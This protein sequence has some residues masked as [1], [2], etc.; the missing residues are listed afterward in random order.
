MFDGKKSS[1]SSETKSQM[2]NVGGKAIRVVSEIERSGNRVVLGAYRDPT[3]FNE[4]GLSVSVPTPSVSIDNLRQSIENDT[5][6]N[7]SN[8]NTYVPEDTTADSGLFDD[9]NVDV[10][11]KDVKEPVFESETEPI[12]CNEDTKSDKATESF[13]IFNSALE[14]LNALSFENPE[15]V[16]SVIELFSDNNG[17]ETE[18]V[19]EILASKEAGEV[20]ELMNI[21]AESTDGGD[22]L[23]SS[24]ELGSQ[25]ESSS[26]SE[27][28]DILL[29]NGFFYGDDG[30]IHCTFDSDEQ[31][32]NYNGKLIKY[33]DGKVIGYVNAK[34]NKA[35][36][37]END[38]WVVRDLT[39]DFVS[40]TGVYIDNLVPEFVTLDSFVNDDGEF[41]VPGS[42]V[43]KFI[44]SYAED[45]NLFRD[46][47]DELL[48]KISDIDDRKIAESVINGAYYEYWGPMFDE[49]AFVTSDPE[50]ETITNEE[51]TDILSKS[52][53]VW[54]NKSDSEPITFSEE[55][56][57]SY[58]DEAKN[59]YDVFDGDMKVESKEQ[60]DNKFD[61]KS[62]VDT[63]IIDDEPKEKKQKPKSR[64]T[65]LSLSC[66]PESSILGKKAIIAS[67]IA[68][69]GF[70]LIRIFGRK[71]GK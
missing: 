45:Q 60:V 21:E 30:K 33:K 39:D 58:D 2:F 6:E 1:T 38:E 19:A 20:E 71:E 64:K 54:K 10:F 67:G 17:E 62:D 7:E 14:G 69:I 52:G 44:D 35:F 32:C 47:L 37:F 28:E 25:S 61:V 56:V 12:M 9:S 4:E 27:D 26:S 43:D 18:K 65:S 8:I 63:T 50:D 34:E 22:V 41:E 70:I 53:F 51:F 48:S 59:L 15:I 68:V 40:K 66:L 3:Y 23:I 13:G 57:S 29:S 55:S 36:L 16:E 31:A 5:N 42:F 49:A 11:V 46:K 24:S